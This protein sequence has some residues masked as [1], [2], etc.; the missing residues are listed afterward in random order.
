MLKLSKE[1]L[2][3]IAIAGVIG[4]VVGAGLSVRH[5]RS[6]EILYVSSIA[7]AILAICRI[8]IKAVFLDEDAPLRRQGPQPPEPL[9]IPDP[10]RRRPQK[11]TRQH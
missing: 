1:T 2:T 5:V 9:E 8:I 3:W 7:L 4:A 6:G 11:S 10:R